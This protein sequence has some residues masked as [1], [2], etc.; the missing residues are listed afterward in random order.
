VGNFPT[1]FF[2]WEISPIDC[3]SAR[4]PKMAKNKNQHTVPA[5][6]LK[7]WC[8][9]DTPKNQT[10]WVWVSEKDGGEPRR[11]APEKLFRK[12]DFYTGT[13]AGGERLLGIE[14]TLGRIET[15][16]TRVRNKALNYEKSLT[17]E[18]RGILCMFAAAAHARTPAQRDHIRKQWTHPLAMMD[19][20]AEYMKTATPENKRKLAS[21]TP[22]SAD[23]KGSLDHGQVRAIVENPM[24]TLLVPTIRAV[25]PLLGRLDMA[26]LQTDDSLGFITSDNPCVWSDPEAYKRPPLY[27]SVGLNRKSIEITMP[28]SPRHCL[29]LNRNGLRGYI[30]I[31]QTVVDDINRTTRFAAAEHFVTRL[32][33]HRPIWFDRGVEP[34]DSWEKTKT[35]AKRGDQP[36]N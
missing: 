14:I 17:A 8:Q 30:P 26:V 34:D 32:P 18:E 7:A 24:Q 19:E 13:G 35:R 31:A 5:C 1:F 12:T 28:L 22:R 23:A 36:N 10:P 29:F 2:N 25:A 33:M 16:F 20:L 11:K 9:P 6:Y 3:S 27:Q 21:M 15:L 4:D